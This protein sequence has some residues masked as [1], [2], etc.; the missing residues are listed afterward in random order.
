MLNAKQ[1]KFV[2][3]Y[4][5]DLNATQAAIRAGYSGKTAYSQGQRL[6]KKVEVAEAI[7]FKQQALAVR[8]EITRDEVVGY[9]REAIEI[10]RKIEAPN[11]LAQAAYKLAVV[12]GLDAPQRQEVTQKQA[13]PQLPAVEE[14]LAGYLVKRGKLNS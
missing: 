13:P 4:A 14:L 8:N 11:A 10:A 9:L 5:I 12:C 7:E 1:S 2:S 3:E 6:L